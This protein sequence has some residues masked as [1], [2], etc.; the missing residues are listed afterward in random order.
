MGLNIIDKLRGHTTGYAVPTF[1]V[2]APGGGG[3]IPIEPNIIV[4]QQN[5]SYVLKNY[6]GKEF[7]H[8]DPA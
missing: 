7:I 6:A 8:Y 2:D 3:K 1:V 5:G 4:S